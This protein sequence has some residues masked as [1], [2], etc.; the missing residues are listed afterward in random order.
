MPSRLRRSLAGAEASARNRREHRAELRRLS[1]APEDPADRDKLRV[2][3]L[4]STLARAVDTSPYYRDLLGPIPPQIE[5]LASLSQLPVTRKQDIIASGLERAAPATWRS[6]RSRWGTSGSSGEPY[7]FAIDRGYVAR[8]RAQRAYAYLQGGASP[9]TRLVEVVNGS[10]R[11]LT[12][13]DTYRT[14]ERI[15]VGYAIEGI[16]EAV[17]QAQPTVLY[18]SRSHLLQIADWAQAHGRRLAP[19]VVCSST[20][21]MLPEDEARLADA[22]GVPPMEVYGS[23]EASNLAFRRPGERTWHILEPRVIVEVVDAENNH[24]SAGEVGELVV[25]TI[26]EPTSP[27]IRYATGDLARV[28]QGSACG[29]SGLLLAALEGRVIDSLVTSTGAVISPWA[30]G[31]NRFW[32]SPERAG[33]VRRW[34]VHQHADRSITVSLELSPGSETRHVSP[35]ITEHLL[36]I[37][38]EL[39]IRYRHVDDVHSKK[40]AKFRAVTTECRTG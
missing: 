33:H 26:T 32:T 4:R 31:S 17:F 34:Q 22:F 39:P 40:N 23:A 1:S 28:Q 35:A 12:A 38:G 20:E 30:V 3:L 19:D 14:F 27:L 5:D 29:G 36:A 37:L 8:H 15:A 10:D 18:G 13:D 21:M 2:Q 11:S 7:S 16:P 25:T 24:V 6:R 9:G